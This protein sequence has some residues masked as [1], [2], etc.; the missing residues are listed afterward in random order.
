MS[1]RIL[2][3][4]DHPIIRAGLRALL[5]R[6]GFTI[7]GE[8]DDGIQAIALAGE[9]LPDIALVDFD[10][11]RMNGIVAAPRLR[12]ASPATRL[13][14]LTMYTDRQYVI[15]AL[16]A[17]YQGFVIKNQAVSDLV[18][19][20]RVVHAGEHYLSPGISAT[21]VDAFTQPQKANGH[22]LTPREQ[23]VLRL[24][25]EGKSTRDAAQALRISVKTAESHRTRIM[26]KLEIHDTASLVRYAI[27]EGFIAP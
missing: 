10:M 2:L 6:E 3:V 19:A 24:V 18:H 26:A 5:E 21:L 15:G 11:P 20:I 1:I 9:Q 16:R 14:M 12:E 23:Q 7:V 17:G 22:T 13:V 4:D 27:R 25:A 8:A